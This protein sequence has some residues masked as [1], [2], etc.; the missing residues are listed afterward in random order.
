MSG[1]SRLGAIEYYRARDFLA[2]DMHKSRASALMGN[3]HFTRYA[4]DVEGGDDTIKA[5]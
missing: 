2:V 4:A 3:M 1:T 5:A